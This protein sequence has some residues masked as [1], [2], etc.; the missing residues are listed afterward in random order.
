MPQDRE[1]WKFR[2]SQFAKEFGNTCGDLRMGKARKASL[3]GWVKGYLRK[4]EGT[5]LAL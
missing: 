1:V 5:G 3:P 2:D 4:V